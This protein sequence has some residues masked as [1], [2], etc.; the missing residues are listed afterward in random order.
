M[1]WDKS[2]FNHQVGFRENDH[3][4]GKNV[5]GK[6]S[7]MTGQANNLNILWF[8]FSNKLLPVYFRTFIPEW[9]CSE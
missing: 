9:N 7:K 4:G 3:M 5:R 2:W 6:G 8:L 1:K